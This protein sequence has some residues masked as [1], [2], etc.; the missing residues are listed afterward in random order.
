MKKLTKN[1]VSNLLYLVPRDL[2]YEICRHHANKE[3]A[4]NRSDFTTNGELWLL[5]KVLPHKNI[6]F[7][8]GAH[9]G[10]WSSQALLVNPHIDLHCFEPS[11]RSFNRLKTQGFG[12]NVIF[13]NFGL[14]ASNCRKTLYLFEDLGEGN[15]LYL[16]RGLE[17]RDGFKPQ[18]MTEQVE[19]RTL[20]SYCMERKIAE[21]DFLKIDVE[22]NELEVIEGGK[23]VFERERVKVAQFE[24]G[25]T[26]IDSGIL[27]RD[28]FDFFDGMNYRFYLLYPRSIRHIPQYDQ[29]LENFQ[30]KNFLIVN[31]KV[32]KERKIFQDD[33]TRT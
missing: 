22:G 16:R 14:G 6:V 10:E 25:G 33:D 7:D 21:I 30:Y 27:L 19:I 8:V 3:F 9:T 18:D 32:A 1:I 17:S 23:D 15:S 13:N 11:Q 26:Y 29:R 5:R 24:Y 28:F 20:D 2:R 4:E 31:N 12:R